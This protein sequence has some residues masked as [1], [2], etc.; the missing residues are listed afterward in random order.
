MR[1]G[2]IDYL[3]CYPFYFHMFEREPLSGIDVMPAYPSSLNRMVKG[4]ELDMSPVSS[5][6]LTGMN[7]H[8]LLIPD[9]CLSSVGYV[10]SVLLRSTIP[11][12][13]LHGRH[14]GITS[15]S[16]TSAV[17]LKILLHRYYHADPIYQVTS[18]NP[19]SLDG[20]DAVLIIGNEAMVSSHEPIQ[21]SYDLAEL[22]LRKTGFPVVFA[23]F[24]VRDDA[25]AKYGREIAS[26]VRSYHRSLGCLAREED[27]VVAAACDRYPDIIYDIRSYYRLFRFEFK[28]DLK[29]ALQF[30]LDTAVELGFLTGGT[31]LRYYE[32]GNEASPELP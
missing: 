29:A 30:Y 14:V 9:F 31:R 23:V 25:I 27:R 22:W 18:P 32:G 6:S 19:S 3:N 1:L 17:L 15:A 5:G 8:V 24:V 2:Y 26:V 21:Y 13:E 7:G 4:G 12:E 10:G 11:I 20:M 28:D 16:E